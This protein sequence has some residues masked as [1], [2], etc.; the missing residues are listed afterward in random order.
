MELS[1]IRKEID[2]IDSAISALLVERFEIVKGVANYKIDNDMVVLDAERE[3]ALL[4]KVRAQ[5]SKPEH[6]QR[7]E[8]VY[9]AILKTSRDMQQ[10]MIDA[11]PLPKGFVAYQG[12]AGSYGEQATTGYFGDE[13]ERMACLD[14]EGVI[15]SVKTGKACYGV[16]PVENSLAGTVTLTNEL[17]QEAGL[18]V[19][20]ETI[21]SI[22]HHLMTRPDVNF[23]E[24]TCIYS[25]PQALE[26][27]GAYLKQI[28]K[29]TVPYINTAV[30]AQKVSESTEPI[31]AIASQRAAKLYG[32]SIVK[33]NI[34]NNADN[35]TRFYIISTSQYIR[36]FANKTSLVVTVNDKPGALY[37]M[38]GLF[39]RYKINMHKI[40]SRPVQK[41]PWEYYFYIDFEGNVNDPQV[42]ALIDDLKLMCDYFY[43]LGCYEADK[44]K[45][46]SNV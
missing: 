21:Q 34:A 45:G 19:V 24:I 14:W 9:Q 25:H 8:A 20:G 18:R 28:N 22:S 3:K 7:I 43:L 42:A 23:D 13:C 35:F 17:I 2:R 36:S 38:L 44:R 1:E 33:S 41:K 31:A 40:E 46:V 27:C 30:S 39:D 5:L 15:E 32:L 37:T 12:T 26:Q 4:K 29:E 16:L 6:A 11:M 10:K